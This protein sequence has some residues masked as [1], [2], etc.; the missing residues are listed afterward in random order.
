MKFLLEVDGPILDF[1][2]AHFRAY[3]DAAAAVGWST[4]DAATYR[5]LVRTKGRD[6]PILPGAS[7]L[8]LKD[9]HAR[10]EVLA[11]ADDVVDLAAARPWAAAVLAALRKLGAVSFLTPGT[12]AAKR[13]AKLIADKLIFPAE[14]IVS[15]ETDPRKRAGQLRE[16]CGGVR[17]CLV[18]AATDALIRAAREAELFC[19][20]TACGTCAVP[21][22]QAAGADTVY[23]DPTELVQSLQSGAADL[24][25]AGLSP[26]SL[27]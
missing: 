26:A 12:N 23:R 5:R 8:K 19:V 24:I 3:R 1:E 2:P 20:G 6:A 11:E 27:G 22:L 18:V 10:F 9:F 7:P 21:R 16:L 13:R 17:R 25:R 4:V 14:N 15:I